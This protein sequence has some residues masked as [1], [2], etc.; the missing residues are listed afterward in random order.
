MTA[1]QSSPI[2]LNLSSGAMRST[3]RRGPRHRL[4]SEGRSRRV[5]IARALD[6]SVATADKLLYGQAA[7][8]ARCARVIAS[9]LAAQDHAALAQWMLPI[10][11][12]LAGPVR[13]TWTDVRHAYD[14][15]DADEDRA[16]AD[17]RHRPLE[18][19]PDAD[20]DRYL[21]AVAREA[22]AATDALALLKAE[23]RRRELAS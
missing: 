15:A 7:L 17:L 4:P 2:T 20:L 14:C 11:A 9:D 22:A 6:V 23:Q 1:P 3:V 21:K 12:A 19:W 5:R 18:E 13:R 8:N 16:Q 10:D